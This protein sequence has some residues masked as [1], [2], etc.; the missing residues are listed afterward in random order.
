[1]KPLSLLL[2]L[3]FASPCFAE[4]EAGPQAE[5]S[6]APRPPPQDRPFPGMVEL[7]VDARDTDHKVMRV[8]E[9]VPV[10]P[11]APLT[12]L[13]PQW[14]PASH[15]PTG[16]VAALAGLKITARGRSVA[17]RR[18][19]LDVYAFH[20]DVPS[21][22]RS[23]E[24]EFQYLSPTRSGTLA[25]SP[26]LVAA[27]W[28]DV[29]LY[30]AGWYA[31]DIPVRARLRLPPGFQAAGSLAIEGVGPE[32]R[33]ALVSLETL[34]D[35]PV[36]A[37]RWIR[38][39]DL[40]R[41]GGAPVRLHLLADRA[42]SL[43][44]PAVFQDR[45]RTL[46]IQTADVFGASHFRR[47]DFLVSLSDALPSDGG[48]EHLRSSES[49]FGPDYLLH[50][51][52]HLLQQ[53]LLAHEYVHSWNGKA[54]V[55]TGLWMADLN[56]PTRDNLLWVY[57]GQTQYWGIV[58]AARSGLRTPQETLD[59]LAVLAAKAQARAGRAWKSMADSALDP[60]F[61]AGHSVAWPDWQGRE[62]Y[63]VDGVLLWLDVDTLIRERTDGRHSLD[64]VAR[65]F[66]GG[67]GRSETVRTY[68][69]ADLCAALNQVAPM[70][71]AGFFAARLEAHDSRRLLDGVERGGYRLAFAKSPT[72]TFRQTEQDD[73]GLD[74]RASLGLLVG[75]QGVVRRVVWDSRAFR[76]GFSPGAKLTTVNG[77]PYSDAALLSAL[78]NEHGAVKL[79]FLQDD[80][81]RSADLIGVSM[82]SYPYLERGSG[83]P[84]LDE[85]LRP[86]GARPLP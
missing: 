66:F 74:L 84:W 2:L 86:V 81:D 36:Y 29:V 11:G 14:E 44:I 60:V 77:A 58:L 20:V 55:P 4:P 26:D 82:P 47:Y 56:T 51:E 42:E 1:M 25:M 63:Y 17:W 80:R 27:L 35:S 34:V 73:G 50:P 9:Q 46:V 13:Y 41:A 19:A 8:H 65:A 72:K 61:D 52:A 28:Q 3:A 62:D 10:V 64:D 15:A 5:P 40:G 31:R 16:N 39:L 23:V 38:D 43:A 53:D 69:L 70:D 37:G 83:R 18:D 48:T 76:A 22:A 85:V 24:L 32:I 45:L 78:Q 79:G 21:G 7:S 49:N 54:L 33:Y 71:W 68:S 30:P 6:P 57:E 67:D 59:L 12:L 75:D